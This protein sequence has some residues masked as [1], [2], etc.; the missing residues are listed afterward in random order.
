MENQNKRFAMILVVVV[1]IVVLVVA[2]PLIMN[3]II[4]AHTVR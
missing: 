1:I 4:A 2:G 3:A